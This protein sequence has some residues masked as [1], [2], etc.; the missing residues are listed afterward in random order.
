MTA[1]A[2]CWACGAAAAPSP[3]YA[4]APLLRCPVC[5]LLFE[6]GRADS[7][8]RELYGDEYFDAYPNS[9][10]YADEASRRYEAR[11][12]VRWV[13]RQRPPGKHLL[14]IGAAQGHFMEAARDAG[15]A[16]VGVEPAPETARSNARRTGLPVHA[17]FVQDAPLSAASFDVACLWH[18]LEHIPEPAGVLDRL[19]TVL[20]PGGVLCLEVPNAAGVDACRGGLNW[21]PLDLRHHVAHYGPPSLRRLLEGAGFAVTHCAS[22][23]ASAY[24][25]P[26]RALNPRTLVFYV[27]QG[28]AMRALPRRSH[29][30]KHD[31]L[32][33]VARRPAGG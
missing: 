25:T 21:P 8:L 9:P 22:F 28:V 2:A 31:L 17:G 20:R 12:R 14:E 13:R 7:D 15:F 1:A 32:R 27:K 30:W 26:R 29:P 4:P 11:S 5:D 3:E 10:G 16:P 24:F 33:A 6:P 18:V 19:R 23:P